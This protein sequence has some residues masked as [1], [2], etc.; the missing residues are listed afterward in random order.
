MRSVRFRLALTYSVLVFALALVVLGAV[1]LGLSRALSGQPVVQEVVFPSLSRTLGGFELQLT[2]ARMV[3]LER[4]VNERALDNLRR[5]SLYT[6]ALLFPLSVVIGWLVAGRALRPVERIGDVAR[7]IQSTDLSRRIR[8]GG[9]DDEFKRLADTFDA[10]LDRLEKGNR[11]QRAFVEDTTH[12][13]RNPLAVMATTLDVALSDPDADVESLRH[14]GE[15]VRRTIDRTS[16]TVDELVTFARQDQRRQAMVAVPL[17]P[18]L[19][20]SVGDYRVAAAARRIDLRTGAT[21]ETMVQGD[22]DSLKRALGNLLDNAVRLAPEGSEIVASC[23]VSG[24]WAWMAVTDQGPGI[25]RELHERIF[26]RSWG[27]A[28]QHDRA[29]RRSGLGL[30]IVRQV[31]AGHGGLVT[32]DSESGSTFTLWLPLDRNASPDAVTADGIHPREDAVNR[33]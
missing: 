27:A 8:L 19:E 33:S 16:R 20:E 13:L 22:R 23:G 12:E 4:L 28:D 24:S 29:R 3:D 25:P 30:A 7:E 1:N 5:Y 2:R 6:V 18:L 10:M 14:A 32:I 17:L 15:V 31:M 9:T 26:E 21:V 11:D